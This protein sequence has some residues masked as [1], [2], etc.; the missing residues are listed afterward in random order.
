MTLVA[1]KNAAEFKT[2]VVDNDKLV[3]V[4]FWAAWCPPC[5]MMAPVL[6]KIA[7]DMSDKVDVVKV[8]VE[9][10][11]ENQQLA[12]AHGVQGIPNL[13]IYKAGKLVDE[14]VGYRPGDVLTTE[15]T[16]HLS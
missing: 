5:R 12:A 7:H 14:L 9:A 16:K 6:E 1:T 4:D 3:I 15:I 13:Q 11:D 10:S 2:N 8:D